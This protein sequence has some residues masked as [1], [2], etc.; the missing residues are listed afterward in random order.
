[1]AEK[2]KLYAQLMKDF[3]LPGEALQAFAAQIR[4]LTPE[5]KAWFRA[6]YAKA[7]VELED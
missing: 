4:A 7:G 1:M 6:E 5:D 3:R 2:I